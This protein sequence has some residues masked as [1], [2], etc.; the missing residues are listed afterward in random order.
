MDIKSGC[1]KKNRQDEKSTGQTKNDEIKVDSTKRSH[2]K[3]KH[4]LYNC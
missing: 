2:N 3:D 1:D 4:Y